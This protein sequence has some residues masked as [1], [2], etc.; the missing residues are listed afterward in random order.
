MV[1]IN[2]FNVRIR[3]DLVKV[4]PMFTAT[5]MHMLETMTSE[6]IVKHRDYYYALRCLKYVCN[7]AKHRT[8]ILYKFGLE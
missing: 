8:D 3:E 5:G 6:E 1:I 7:C 4:S 2:S